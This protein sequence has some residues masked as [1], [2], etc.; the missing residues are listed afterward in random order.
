MIEVSVDMK[1][2][3][4]IY[5]ELIEKRLDEIE[6]KVFF[7]TS[8]ELCKYLGM[9]WNTVTTCLMVDEDFPRVRLGNQWRFPAHE[10]KNYME[11]YYE[12]VRDNGGDILK[13]RRP[14]Q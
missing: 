9:S 8:K 7:Y 2:L 4:A 10:V 6:Q 1:A 5:L 11:K 12:Q 14:G 3:E 13:Y